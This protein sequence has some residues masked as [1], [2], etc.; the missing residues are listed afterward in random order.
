[1]VGDHEADDHSVGRRKK[2]KYKYETYDKKSFI[3]KYNTVIYIY[4][5]NLS[6]LTVLLSF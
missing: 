3:L 6:I 1:M 2:R 5:N 4:F